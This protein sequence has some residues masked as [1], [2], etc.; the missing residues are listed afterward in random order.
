MKTVRSVIVAALI[1]IA[2][3]SSAAAQGTAAKAVQPKGKDVV[4]IFH[5]DSF[6]NFTLMNKVAEYVK[7]KG[8]KVAEDEEFNADGYKAGD[9]AAVVF[10]VKHEAK[11]SMKIVDAFMKKNKKQRN[12]IVAISHEWDVDSSLIK[13]DYDAL[14]AA[15]KEFEQDDI[16]RKIKEKLDGVLNK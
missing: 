1:S 4:M 16:V 15:S 14:T 6:F 3:I 11:G 2:L 9:Y 8:L 7:A 5:H 13:K 12:M 10:L